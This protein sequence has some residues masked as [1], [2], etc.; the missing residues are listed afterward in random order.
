MAEFL[1]ERLS[2]AV[3]YGASY[4]D[5]YRVRI[6][7][8][9]DDSE[10]RELLHPFPVREF[11]FAYD[12]KA[13]TLY[14]SIANTYHRAFGKYAGFRVKCLDDYTT[15]GQTGTPTAFDQTLGLVVAGTTYQLQKVYGE[16]GTPLS[17]GLPYRTLFKPVSGTTRVAIGALEILNTPIVNWSVDTTTGKVTFGANKGQALTGITKA[18]QAVI[19]VGSHAYAPGEYAHLSGV[20]GMTEI[21][22]KRGLITAVGGVTITV[23]INS[24]GFTTYTSGG[25]VNTRPQSGETVKGGCEFDIPARFDSVL[26]I[27]QNLIDYRDISSL[28][29]IE[30]LN[31]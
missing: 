30:L 7:K 22:G 23:A 13:A 11:I 28:T 21:N 1:E 26:M 31:P 25:T 4:G 16:G 15:N 17:I 5:D 29:L 3:K 14:Q 8:T 27:T 6:T 10:Y 18:A 20:S 2:I 12:A 19:T 24:T 9:S